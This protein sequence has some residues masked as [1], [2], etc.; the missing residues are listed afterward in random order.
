MEAYIELY[1]CIKLKVT[2][3]VRLISHLHPKSK[4]IKYMYNHNYML[5]NIYS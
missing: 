1:Y 4:D 5:L 3:K 2:I